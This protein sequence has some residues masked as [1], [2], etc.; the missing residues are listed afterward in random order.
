[1]VRDQFVSINKNNDNTGDNIQIILSY[2]TIE[3]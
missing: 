2:F 3:T 1:M